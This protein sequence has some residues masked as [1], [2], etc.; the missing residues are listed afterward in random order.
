MSDRLHWELRGPV[1]TLDVHRTWNYWQR[2]S[3]ESAACE[4]TESG[5]QSIVE[6]RLD[7]AIFRHWHHNPDGSEWTTIHTFDEAGRL[8]DEGQPVD[9]A[10]RQSSTAARFL[11]EYDARG[12][13]TSKVT[14]VR[15]NDTQDFFITSTERRT[16][17]YFDPI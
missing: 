2:G 5:D 8:T 9:R 17:K 15:Q 16:L 1:H 12:N 3:G 4:L 13:W 6:F 10:V 11:Y 7:G 14:E